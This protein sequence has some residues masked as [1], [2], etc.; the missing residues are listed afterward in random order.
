MSA[1]NMTVRTANGV[2]RYQAIAQSSCD[3]IDAAIDQFGIA[4]ISALPV[5][6]NHGQI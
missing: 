5:G 4:V 2:V 3:A 1:F 6:V